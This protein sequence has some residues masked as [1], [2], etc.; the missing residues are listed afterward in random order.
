MLRDAPRRNCI[1][2][3][4]VSALDIDAWIEERLQTLKARHADHGFIEVDSIEF[5]QLKHF[6]TLLEKLALATHLNS[7]AVLDSLER[8]QVR[9]SQLH[10]TNKS[11]GV[12]SFTPE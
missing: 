6:R 7:P 9:S 2:L 4:K 10:A 11:A 1:I 5:Q 12:L 3:G 8:R